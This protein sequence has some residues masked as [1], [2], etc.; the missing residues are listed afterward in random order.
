MVVIDIGEAVLLDVTKNDGRMVADTDVTDWIDGEIG[1]FAGQWAPTEMHMLISQHVDHAWLYDCSSHDREI[2]PHSDLLK[3]VEVLPNHGWRGKQLVAERRL[4]F[5]RLMRL[6]INPLAPMAIASS[7]VL[8][9][10][11]LFSLVATNT[12]VRL[13]PALRTLI[14]PS[15]AA[16]Q[17]PLQPAR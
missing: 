2:V 6:Y 8:G 12:T 1:V 7:A 4:C 9:R 11:L 17:A 16:S 5:P 13:P 3:S 15:I 10:S 14:M